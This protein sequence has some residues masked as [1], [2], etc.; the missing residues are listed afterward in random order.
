MLRSIRIYFRRRKVIR[1]VGSFDE[2]GL[3]AA[4]EETNRQALEILLKDR[5]SP[6]ARTP[7]GLP[8][9]SL[10]IRK[11]DLH[12]VSML[13]DAK[14]NI[15]AQDKD[16][17][18][19]LMKAI[20]SGNRHIFS[21]LIEQDPELDMVDRDGETALFK[22]VREGNTTFC[23]KIIDMGANVDVVNQN[24]LT[25]L[26]LAVD[27]ARI[28]IVKSLLQAGADP[29]VKDDSGQTVL[30]RYHGNSRIS[31]MLKDALARRGIKDKSSGTANISLPGLSLS[32]LVLPF[33]SMNEGI[34]GQ[35]PQLGSLLIGLAEGI[36]ESIGA[37][38]NLQQVEQKSKA[39]IEQINL[40]FLRTENATSPANEK[41]ILWLQ[42]QIR[43]TLQ[44]MIEL[45][46]AGNR[47]TALLA[48][49]PE[50]TP[51]ET[52]G[53]ITGY[54]NQALLEAAATGH[55]ELVALLVSAGADP[56]ATNEN[57]ETASD[58]ALA[59]EFYEIVQLLK[60]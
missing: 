24:G 41:A 7:K 14:A 37:T 50:E 36:L 52:A 40:D 22:A 38:T 35:L 31:Q 21:L 30:D 28:G 57:G 26:M 2:A 8:A 27:Q 19:P 51:G 17:R 16:G 25:P 53:E 39:M 48:R 10:A 18:T 3:L 56:S 15:D 60:G 49:K 46:T 59:K 5:I 44:L 6:D 58:L 9:L 4:V 54:L 11:G 1:M 32:G 13:I 33:L 45:R 42:E 20:E 55:R 47:V 23:R 12:V 43:R 29:M 34:I